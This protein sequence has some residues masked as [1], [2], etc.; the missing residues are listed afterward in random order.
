M[1]TT[2]GMSAKPLDQLA[3]RLLLAGGALDDSVRHRLHVLERQLPRKVSELNPLQAPERLA[4][5]QRLGDELL[6]DRHQRGLG[7][8]DELVGLVGELG[9]TAAFF[10]VA[11][12]AL[13]YDQ[14]RLT[15]VEEVEQRAAAAVELDDGSLELGLQALGRLEVGGGTPIGRVLLQPG[16][17]IRD[18][19]VRLG[20]RL[21]QRVTGALPVRARPERPF[22]LLGDLPPEVLRDSSVDR[23]WRRH[24]AL[25]ESPDVAAMTD[26]D[27]GLAQP[28]RDEGDQEQQRQEERVDPVLHTEK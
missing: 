26:S 4:D 17:P 7:I 19:A 28:D 24:D 12:A 25:P 10:V 16:P 22:A 14:L 18:R 27:E 20:Q 6:P 2:M 23:P 3:Q 8:R 15:A 21:L 1:V 5:P 11:L 9:Q 13:Q